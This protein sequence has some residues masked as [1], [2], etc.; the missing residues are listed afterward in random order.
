MSSCILEL[1]LFCTIINIAT[2]IS[3]AKLLLTVGWVSQSSL[4]PSL[5]TKSNNSL[6]PAA[7]LMGNS[8]YNTLKNVKESTS[9]LS[10]PRAFALTQLSGVLHPKTIFL[11]SSKKI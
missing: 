2:F 4:F 10:A 1:L 11:L 5:P 3:G 7:K 8:H 9:R 6:L